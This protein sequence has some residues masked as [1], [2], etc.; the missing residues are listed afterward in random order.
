MSERILVVDDDPA[1][2]FVLLEILGEHGYTAF[3]APG[4]REAHRLLDAE[5]FALVLSDVN[6][7][8][9]SGME[10]VRH[11]IEHHPGV[12]AVMVTGVDDP[13]IAQA[14]LEL[15]AYGYLLKPFGGLEVAIQVSNA[16]RRRRLELESRRRN[17]E[18]EAE[19]AERTAELRE[20][21]EE[22]IRRFAAA[23]EL[24]NRETGDH[25]GRVGALCAQ[26]AER[27]GWD[28]ARAAELQLASL[29]HDVGKIAIPDRLLLKAGPLSVDE[30]G[31]MERHTTIGHRMLSG[32]ASSLLGL[33]AEVA[34]HHHER[35]DGLGYPFGLRGEEIPIE[36]RIVTV[37]DVF[38]ALTSDRPYRRAFS[39]G[40]ALAMLA[41]DRGRQF[42]PAVLDAFLDALALSD[43]I[44]QDA[45]Q[46]R[47]RAV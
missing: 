41:A 28:E 19:V 6:M 20:S 32:S 1:I 47:R 40:Q 9:G 4:A 2:R 15:G 23:I 21:H 37:V 12:A 13:A 36:A 8:D 22:T 27:L 7:P 3:G 42:D 43:D 25:V 10:L 17:G 31:Q 35:W 30:R 45:R 11:A 14:A 44:W 16:L 24:R 33:A 46:G 29:L 18:L 34:L 39:R 26:L 38:D 5:E